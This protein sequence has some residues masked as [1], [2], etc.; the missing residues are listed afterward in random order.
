MD[1]V[2]R[3]YLPSQWGKISPSQKAAL[4]LLNKV[5]QKDLKRIMFPDNLAQNH[6]TKFNIRIGI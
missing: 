6:R 1:K 4:V 2:L 3:G 5:Y